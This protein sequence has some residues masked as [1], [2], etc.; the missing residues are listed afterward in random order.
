MTDI[1]KSAH[2]VVNGLVDE[3]LDV[4]G[5]YAGTM[6]TATA[7]GCLDIVKAQV[8]QTELDFVQADEDEDEDEDD[9]Y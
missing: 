7:L 4:I 2:D 8:I 6:V 1:D 9:E 5:K 3:L